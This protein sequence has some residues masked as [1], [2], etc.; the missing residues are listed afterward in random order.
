MHPLGSGR[1]ESVTVCRD[2]RG[3]LVVADIKY[4]FLGL[5]VT[6]A[7]LERCT[8]LA[9]SIC[10]HMERRYPVPVQ[11]NK[12]SLAMEIYSHNLSCPWTCKLSAKRKGAFDCGESQYLVKLSVLP[13]HSKVVFIT[14]GRDPQFVNATHLCH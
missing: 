8:L 11:G 2:G 4:P 1:L 5:H 13:L 6:Q 3:L 14:S 10:S 9:N 7:C 12:H